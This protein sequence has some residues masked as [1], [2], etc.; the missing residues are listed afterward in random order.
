M[1]TKVYALLVAYDSG[2]ANDKGIVMCRACIS[3]TK[4]VPQPSTALAVGALYNLMQ[5]NVAEYAGK[6]Y[7]TAGHLRRGC[8]D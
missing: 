4:K 7:R 2:N 1:P 8:W 5:A 6:W 3:R